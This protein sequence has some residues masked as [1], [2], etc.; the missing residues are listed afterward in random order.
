[1]RIIGT[2]RTIEQNF[3]FLTNLVAAIGNPDDE[4]L[5]EEYSINGKS[6]IVCYI[7]IVLKCLVEDL[8]CRR[9]CIEKFSSPIAKDLRRVLESGKID[10]ELCCQVVIQIYGGDEDGRNFK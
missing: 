9:V 2:I 7:E 4:I 1:M 8:K 3:P 6:G 10:Q 5:W